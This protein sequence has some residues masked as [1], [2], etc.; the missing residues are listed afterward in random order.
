MYHVDRVNSYMEHFN[1]DHEW[2]ARKG[3]LSIL[4]ERAIKNKLLVVHSC[5]KQDL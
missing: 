1:D 4:K 3:V 2:G 5:F